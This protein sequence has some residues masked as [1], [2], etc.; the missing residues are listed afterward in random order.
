MMSVQGICDTQV[1]SYHAAREA[2]TRP[3]TYY[4]ISECHDKKG[5][6]SR[7]N[8]KG[9]LCKSNISPLIGSFTWLILQALL[10][11]FSFYNSFME[12]STDHLYKIMYGILIESSNILLQFLYISFIE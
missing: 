10:P 8:A 2:S 6:V 5:K 7:N 4:I 12:I 11:L 9:L 3:S 1:S